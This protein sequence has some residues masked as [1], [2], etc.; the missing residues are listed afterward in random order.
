MRAVQ[1]ADD[2]LHERLSLPPERVNPAFRLIDRQGPLLA[3]PKR[4]VA[5][6]G[7][8][9][10]LSRL[11]S[12]GIAA[13]GVK[14][15]RVPDLLADRRG[16]IGLTGL[17]RGIVDEPLQVLH[18][19]HAGFDRV[20][21]GDVVRHVTDDVHPERLRLL[22]DGVEDRPWHD[23]VHLD[24]VVAAR[25]L[26]P[27]DAARVRRIRGNDRISL[28]PET[29]DE[30]AGHRICRGEHAPRVDH[31][32]RREHPGEPRHVAHRR[33]AGGEVE[34]PSVGGARVDV[35]VR[36]TWRREPSPAFDHPGVRDLRFLIDAAHPGNLSFRD[37]HALFRGDRFRHW[38]DDFDVAQDHDPGRRLSLQL[39]QDLRHRGVLLD[40]VDGDL[41]RACGRGFC[42]CIA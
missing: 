9:Q 40:L 8:T 12:M 2:R 3:L 21:D 6:L 14:R 34:Q 31:V 18:R 28:H 23:V 24:E 33:H 32:A 11:V 5:H 10:E 39:S 30:G 19:P 35:H 1:L 26:L 27:D 41:R 36:E 16:E 7:R 38:I 22:V 20:P 25:S 4:R 29:V 13:A 42:R 17:E 37:D 15:G